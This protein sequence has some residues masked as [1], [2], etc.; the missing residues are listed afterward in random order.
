MSLPHVAKR[1]SCTINVVSY[2]VPCKVGKG[3]G[4]RSSH[5]AAGGGI[6]PSPKS[7]SLLELRRIRKSALTL[8]VQLN[9]GF[10]F[11]EN[12]QTSNLKYPLKSEAPPELLLPKRKML[13]QDVGRQ[14]EKEFHFPALAPSSLAHPLSPGSSSCWHS[15]GGTT[16]K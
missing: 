11:F 13:W 3:C 12:N 14:K 16:Q 7:V 4:Y 6:L 2:K 5:C 15:C 8:T 9:A 10:K 1:F